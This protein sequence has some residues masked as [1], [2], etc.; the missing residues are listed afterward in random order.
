MRYSLISLTSSGDID[1]AHLQNSDHRKQVLLTGING[2][3]GIH[4]A[5]VLIDKG[6]TVVGTVRSESKIEYI[7]NLFH[8]AFEADTLSFAIV[9]DITKDGAFEDVLKSKSFDAVIHTSSPFVIV[10]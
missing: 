5:K 4:I 7:R 6:Y 3:I 1:G 2:F 9:P 8:A 10:G